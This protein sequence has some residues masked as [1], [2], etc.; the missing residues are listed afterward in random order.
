MFKW[1]SDEFI[2][3]IQQERADKL[4]EEMCAHCI[5]EYSNDIDTLFE[6]VTTYSYLED[7][8]EL[9]KNEFNEKIV[10]AAIPYD[11]GIY[12]AESSLKLGF[13]ALDKSWKDP[14]PYVEH[15]FPADYVLPYSE[16]F[17]HCFFFFFTQYHEFKGSEDCVKY[18][19]SRV[20]RL[21]AFL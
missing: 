3:P 21:K 7:F 6:K 10:M 14:L 12:S 16:S 4:L 18:Y 17:R 20:N 2:A 11:S 13:T 8:H 19:L 5:P 15:S 1:C 9:I